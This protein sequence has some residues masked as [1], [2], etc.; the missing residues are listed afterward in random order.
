MDG[1]ADK[2]EDV[3]G[4]PHLLIDVAD[5]TKPAS[6]KVFETGRFPTVEEVPYFSGYKMGVF[7]S[8]E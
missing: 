5:K 6:T 3:I 7:L 1:S 2:E 8:L 4:V